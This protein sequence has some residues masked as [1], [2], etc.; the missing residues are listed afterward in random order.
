MKTSD[1]IEIKF[2]RYFIDGKPV[3]AADFSEGMVC[4]F[5]GFRKFGIQPVCMLTGDDLQTNRFI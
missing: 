2:Q 4:E 3:C 5:L 1:T